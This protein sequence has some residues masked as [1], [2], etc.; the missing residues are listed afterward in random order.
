[1]PSLFLVLLFT[2]ATLAF[3]S[4]STSLSES[5]VSFSCRSAEPPIWNRWKT[6]EIMENLAIGA[7]K[8][9]RFKN[10]RYSTIIKR[11]IKIIYLD[12]P[13]SY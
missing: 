12:T 9:S 11:H 6:S 3:K 8:M 5:V 13:S 10:E 4:F 2:P 7:K 1:M